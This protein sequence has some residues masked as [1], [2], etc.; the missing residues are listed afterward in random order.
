MLIPSAWD[1]LTLGPSHGHSPYP[2]IVSQT[3]PCA[4]HQGARN[5][6][7]RY[8]HSGQ[9]LPLHRV[10]ARA[11]PTQTCDAAGVFRCCATVLGSLRTTGLSWSA[12]GVNRGRYR[13]AYAGPI[14]RTGP[15]TG[16]SSLLW[17]PRPNVRPVFVCGRG[18][19][20]GN[21]TPRSPSRASTSV[22][23]GDSAARTF[24]AKRRR[25]WRRSQPLTK[26]RRHESWHRQSWHAG[27]RGPSM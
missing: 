14:S 16:R 19:Q 10:E 20:H 12:L 27:P 26:L 18:R 15:S 25:A 7:V 1:P 23:L 21:R 6:C 8:I 9:R 5:I 13:S 24:A 3:P 17:P 4:I 2:D 22:R 11:V